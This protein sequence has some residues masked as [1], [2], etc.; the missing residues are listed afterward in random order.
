MPARQENSVILA[1]MSDDMMALAIAV[2]K[3]VKG[4]SVHPAEMEREYQGAVK[5]VLN[6]RQAQ[7][8]K[9]L[10]ENSNR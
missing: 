9:W 8:R 10:E 6:Y 5:I 2:C 3:I 1:D 7:E 4:E